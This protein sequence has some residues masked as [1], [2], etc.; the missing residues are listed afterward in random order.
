MLPKLK[1]PL[2]GPKAKALIARDEKIMS[3]SYTRDYP[4]V[5]DRGEGCIVYDPDGNSFLDFAAGIAVC[6]TGHHHPH[7]TQAIKDQADRFIH[8]SGTDF[9]YGNQVDLAERL[10][11]RAPMKG[12]KKVFFTNSGAEA[13]EA[14][15][16]LSRFHTKRTQ[17]ITF[18]G[19]FH[20]RT[21]GALSLTASKTQ[22]RK[23]FMPLVP[24]VTN[25]HYGY[26]YRCPYH[27]T[28]PECGIH[29]MNAIEK[30]L[31]KHTVDPNDV[32]MILMEAVQGEG[33]YV[34]P[35]REVIKTV[36]DIC[37]R[38][39]IM[40]VIDEVQSGMG[41]TGKMFA[42]EHFGVEPDILCTAK[43]IASG[44]PLGAI[45]AKKDVMDW[46]YGSHASTF[47]GN[48][49]SCAAALATMDLLEGKVT[50]SGV[51]KGG[52]IKNAE[53]VG[54]HLKARLGE[55]KSRHTIIGDVRGLGLMVGAEIVDPK[56]GRTQAPELRNKILME[57]FKQG[58]LILGCGPNTVRFAP[59]LIVS[60]E[61]AD[62]A[63][64][65]LD[66]VFTKVV[67]RKKAR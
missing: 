43:G 61:Q 37:R 23:R 54:K 15:F 22:Q 64:D 34:V 2:P 55:L 30:I 44:M 5:M 57:A 62:W 18:F 63:V 11:A 41:R 67:S 29:C 8:M 19:A 14:A 38:H 3:P 56:D 52:L 17:A 25:T 4:F 58:L 12:D 48:P 24:G 1:T 27:L 26:C 21:M 16:K 39:G 47:G 35:P 45:I 40:F 6:S 65:C 31:F 36:A 32:A 10:A 53:V 60:V 42:I 46:E 13:V 66:R 33:G 59:P 28:Y 51:P 7:V 9:Y 50:G 49:V 20:G